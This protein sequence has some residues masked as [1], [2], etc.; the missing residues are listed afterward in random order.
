VSG[1][2]AS[3]VRPFV[4]RDGELA[5]VQA[6][7][8]EVA[9]GQGRIVFV[10]GHM[11]KGKTRLA[12][13]ALDSARRRAFLVLVG[14]TPAAGSGLA[15][16]PLLA[17]FGSVLRATDPAQRDALVG[18]L[19]RLGRLWPELHLP[20]PPPVQEPELERALL[21]E[22]VA[23]L[24]E[25]LASRAPMAVFVDDL[26]W[27][28]APSLAL[29]GYLL[30]GLAAL[31]VLLIA[32]YR[33]EGVT[34]NKALRQ[35]VTDVRRAGI[36]TELPLEA[37]D[38]EAV[39][40]LVAGILGGAPPPALLELAA[41]AAGSPLFVEALVRGLIE[42]GGLVRTGNG[43][44]MTG[45]PTALPR[46][47]RDLVVDRLD[48]LS[49]D[50]RSTVELIAHT[51]QGLPH[52]LLEDAADLEPGPL[53]DVVRRLVGADLVIQDEDGPDVTYRLAHPFIGEVVAGEMPA[54]AGRR[55]HARLAGTGERL[56][57]RD[58]DLLAYHYSRAGREVDE[59][60]ALDVLLDAGERA[61]HLAAHEEAA[62]H[63]G[64]ALPFVRD[65]KR[66]DLVAHV[67]ERMGESWEPLGETAAAMAVWTEA[68][69][70]RERAADVRSV[71]RIR[72]RLAF[73]AQAG[74]DLSGARQ[75]LAAGIEALRE[76]P[77]SDELVDLYAARQFIDTPLVDPDRAR[78]VVVE[79]GRLAQ[80]LNSPRATAE[81]RLAEA[82]LLWMAGFP[83]DPV[84]IAEEAARI[85]AEAGEWLL[86]RRAHRELAWLGYVVGRPAATR[87]HC[88]AQSD[89]DDRLGDAAHRSGPSFQLSLAEQLAGDFDKSIAL[90]EEAVTQARR[91]GQRRAEAMALGGLAVALIHRGD[92]DAA[93]Q[94]VGEAGEVFPEVLNDPRGGR[95]FVIVPKLM[96]ALERGDTATVIETAGQWGTVNTLMHLNLTGTAQ[97]AAGDVNGALATAEAL[98]NEWPRNPYSAAQADRLVGLVHHAR[99]EAEAGRR[100]LE[101]SAAALEA[102]GLPF[103]T[104]VSRLHLGTVDSVRRALTDFEAMGAARYADRARRALRILGVRP[105]A[106]RSDRRAAEPLSR[107]ELEV[108]RL[109]ARGLTNAEIAERLVLSVRTVETHLAHIY[110]RLGLSSRAA[111][112][113][114]VTEAAT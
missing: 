22:A 20:L 14:R 71:A 46:E 82:S 101:C 32:T 11:G 38:P 8:S 28:D 21:F 77:P 39:A 47:V 95:Y 9:E 110:G 84:P 78:E 54:V 107:R 76:L 108:A 99:G 85:A 7:L 24:F 27:A 55:L 91:Y 43:W 114:W 6:A 96:L 61:H 16:A 35:F 97:L 62:R 69:V 103:E 59:H 10:T 36:G 90:A 72:R 109:V 87:R 52:D 66:P 12:E 73:T 44:T 29:L 45:G 40:A 68:L 93:E 4:G 5:R 86:A 113:V 50:E 13:E 1:P 104:A 31:P 3:A 63:F 105:P 88:Q 67:L 25:R 70:E 79:L 42:A 26:H 58:L 15:Y 65:G 56:R 53:L 102:L 75:H 112:A 30:P 100:R 49:G 19:P 18:D 60:R 111:L 74:G 80:V 106:A 89:I 64:A 17:A 33:P 48:L 41:G 23:R 92:L 34:H 81:A 37:L 51:A 2:I 57:P 94:R 98:R 83:G